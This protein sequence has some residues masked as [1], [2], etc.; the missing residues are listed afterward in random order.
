MQYFSGLPFY[1]MWAILH[2]DHLLEWA[3]P[4]GR[5]F[6]P[7]PNV[8]DGLHSLS[9]TRIYSCATIGFISIS[10][11]TPRPFFVD[12]IHSDKSIEAVNRCV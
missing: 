12:V 11:T 10:A 8:G 7:L 3:I 2:H 1:V 9:K 5:L 6:H 4:D